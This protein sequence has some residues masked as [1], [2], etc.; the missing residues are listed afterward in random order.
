MFACFASGAVSSCTD[1]DVVGTMQASIFDHVDD[2]IEVYAAS[3]EWRSRAGNIAA[4]LREGHEIMAVGDSYLLDPKSRLEDERVTVP[5]GG[6]YSLP[7]C[8]P[9]RYGSQWIVAGAT[10][11]PFG[12][13]QL[14][15]AGHSHNNGDPAWDPQRK[16]YWRMWHRKQRA[17]LDGRWKYLR[18]DAHDYLF[19]IGVDERERANQATRDPAR[20]A[21]MRAEWERW[22]ATMPGIPEDARV[23][24][25]FGEAQ[26]PRATY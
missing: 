23:S 18:V 22:A 24:L 19:D 3:P 17:L 5:S 14:V 6:D 1:R 25:V 16:L 8:R 21:A 4:V 12:P 15:L 11:F 7:W 10:A 2:R 20:L 13:Q 9:V 26:M